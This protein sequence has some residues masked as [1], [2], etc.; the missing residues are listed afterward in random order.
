MVL[1]VK[2]LQVKKVDGKKGKMVMCGYKCRCI[3]ERFSQSNEF[4]LFSNKLSIL[5]TQE[6]IHIFPSWLKN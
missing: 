5:I 3:I 1:I 4:H 2:E 6:L